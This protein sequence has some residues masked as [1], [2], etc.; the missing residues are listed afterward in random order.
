[1]RMLLVDNSAFYP[2]SPLFLEA[3]QELAAEDS[4]GLQYAFIDLAS[5]SRSHR[6]IASRVFRRLSGS[7]PLE[8]KALNQALLECSRFF[9]PDLVLI[10]KGA[11]IEPSILLSVKRETGA[12]LVNYATDDPFNTQVNTRQLVESIPLYDL[13][14]S[15]KRAIMPDVQE[16][17]CPDVSYVP[18]GWKPGVHFPEFPTTEQE[19]KRFC[20]DVAFIGGCDHERVPFFKHLLKAM[21]QL[22]LALYGGFWNRT[23]GL[24]SYWRGF[25]MGRDFR[26]ALGG[27]KIALNLVRRANRDG[28]VMRSFEIPACGAFMLAERTDEHQDLFAES[29]ECAYF[30]SAD[31]LVEKVRYYLPRGE[32]RLAIAARGREAVT[33]GKH[34]YR[35]RLLQIINEARELMRLRPCVV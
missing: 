16:A 25:A 21:P 12:F 3:L 31:E 4:G 28:H 34:T 27:T 32:E 5:F 26:M 8:L 23:I 10:C 15:T 24:R 22:D 11:Y 1:M 33:R 29:R 19:R 18:F 6:S 2:S 14:V 30:D 35:D 9:S 13:Y 20:S 7:A 17:G